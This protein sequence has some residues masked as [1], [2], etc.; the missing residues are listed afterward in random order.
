MYPTPDHP[1]GAGEQPWYEVVGSFVYPLDGHPDGR[2]SAP[3]Y[4]ARPA[5]F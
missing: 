2:G 5:P 1:Q 3:R 4:Q